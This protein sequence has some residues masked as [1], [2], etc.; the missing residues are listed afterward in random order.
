MTRHSP[1]FPF[2]LYLRIIAVVILLLLGLWVSPGIA[3]NGSKYPVVVDG[4]QIFQVSDSGQFSAQER[5]KLINFQLRE[6]VKSD[7]DIQVK[8]EER[9]QSPTILLGDRYLLT[10][11]EKD[12]LPGSTTNEQASLWVKQIE[13]ALA[14][15]QSER[16]FQ[17]IRNTSILTASILLGA[18]AISWLL[19]LFRKRISRIV[20]VKLNDAHAQIPN[21]DLPKGLAL[22]FDFMLSFARAGIWAGTLIYITNLFPYTRQWS[23]QISYILTSSFTSQF[24]TL[25]NNSYSL[26]N[27]L[28]LVILLFALIIFAGT[29]TNIFRS[30]VLEQ[31]AGINRGAQEAIAILT[32]YSLIVVG[33]IVLL[34]IWGLDLSSITI[35][36]SAFGI[37]IGFGFQDIAKNFGS[38]LILVLE[39]PIQV[40]D[41]IEVGNLYG[42]V[43]R[44]SARSTE[45]RTLDHIS[46]I[47]PNSRLL[48]T[49]VINWSHR[50]PISRLHL[51]VGVSYNT[52]PELV[53][54]ALLDATKDQPNVLN[55]PPPQVFFKGFGDS[56][57]NFELL[58]WTAEPHK[59]FL[60]KSNLYFSIYEALRKRNIEIPF[61]QHD[62]HLR[63]GNLTL[64]P[65]VEKAL[66]QLSEESTNGYNH[67]GG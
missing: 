50:N 60:T 43:E 37:G 51:P 26:I 52:E 32:K 24:I 18:F 21:A 48:E 6:V 9:N 20:Q 54:E 57:L 61:P 53:K 62:L 15:S 31:I 38:G 67:Q 46:I 12:V 59:Q 45:I 25:G 14:Q 22:L 65:Q 8:I 64:S 36:A 39:R 66:L 3:Q 40:S 11:T 29:I 10:V 33:S 27:L 34:Q 56:A 28:I 30:R 44:I 49:E 35:L 41:F 4:Y 23:Y 55:T 47:V 1:R 2:F 13:E 17:Y 7:K 42:T 16:S 5:A 58:V 19:G 63:S